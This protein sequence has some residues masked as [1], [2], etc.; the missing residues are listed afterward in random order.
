[1]GSNGRT[2]RAWLGGIALAAFAIGGSQVLAVAAREVT[3]PPGLPSQGAGAELVRARRE[4]ALIRAEGTVTML[5][6]LR[7]APTLPGAGR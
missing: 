4:Q 6:A 2:R 3:G 1:V 7:S 5:H